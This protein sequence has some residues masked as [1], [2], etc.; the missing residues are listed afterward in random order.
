[1]KAFNQKNWNERKKE[2]GKLAENAFLSF[3]SKEGIKFEHFGMKAESE[4]DYWNL[5]LFLRMRPD[6]ICQKDDKTFF[7]EVKGCGYDGIIKFK[8][9]C[10]EGLYIWQSHLPVYVFMF[11]SA[12][13]K[14]SFVPYRDL[15]DRLLKSDPKR[16]ENDGKLYFPLSIKELA[17]MSI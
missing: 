13:H 4:L 12:R 11:D 1:M 9:E 8:I 3:A 17:W 5:A 2:L 7:V 15:R 16:F 10:M 6:F 14:C